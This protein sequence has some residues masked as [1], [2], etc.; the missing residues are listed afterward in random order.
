MIVADMSLDKEYSPI[1]GIPEFTKGARG[2]AFGWD[3]PL[4]NDPR[5]VSAQTLSGTGALRILSEFLKKFRPSTIYVSNPTWG[6]H[7]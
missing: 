4:V 7:F 6:N 3:H 2:V 1:D 5:V